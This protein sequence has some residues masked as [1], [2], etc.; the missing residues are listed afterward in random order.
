L[1]LR[2]PDLAVTLRTV[3]RTGF[4]TFYRGEIGA[5]IVEAVKRRDGLLVAADLALHRSLWA[6][7]VAA[8]YRDLVVYNTPPPTQG[9]AALGMFVR[10]APHGR[11][12]PA[13]GAGFAC[14]FKQV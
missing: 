4:N 13:P 12:G 8:D 1:L 9:L 14:L 10:L 7:P 6:E 5:A 2:N 11:S 3:G